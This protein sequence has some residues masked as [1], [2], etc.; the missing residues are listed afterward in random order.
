MP[1]P[2]LAPPYTA[3]ELPPEEWD[4]LADLPLGQALPDPANAAILVVEH[5]G[6]IVAAWAALTTVHLDGLYVVPAS[7]K[8]PAVA[9]TLVQGMSALLEAR[10]IPQVVT[11]TQTDEVAALA[12]HIGGARVG[13][14]WT[15]PVPFHGG[16]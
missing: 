13:D 11:V 7:R 15:I 6:V 3:R 1:T 4:R 16:A 10:G 8:H 9:R 5:D 14:L 2:T 12:A